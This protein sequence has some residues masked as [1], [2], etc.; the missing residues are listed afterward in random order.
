MPKNSFWWFVILPYALIVGA[1]FGPFIWFYIR[2]LYP[3]LGEEHVHRIEARDYLPRD[4]V[5][6]RAKEYFK[7][8]FDTQRH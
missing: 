2:E 6:I 1:I 3:D 8:D 4:R 5:E 7:I